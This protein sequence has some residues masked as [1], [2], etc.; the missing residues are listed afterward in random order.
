MIKYEIEHETV[1]IRGHYPMGLTEDDIIGWPQ[2]FVE[3][4]TDDVFDDEEEARKVFDKTY[5]C[6]PITSRH[7]GYVDAQIYRLVEYEYDDDGELIQSLRTLEVAVE[8]LE[9][10]EE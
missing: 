9:S 7:R 4:F 2:S 5:S 1:E 3:V 6:L 10:E 8:P